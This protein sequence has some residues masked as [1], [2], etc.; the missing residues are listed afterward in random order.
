VKADPGSPQPAAQPLDGHKGAVN[1]VAF[2][3]AGRVF[4]TAGRDNTVLVRD[5]T[6]GRPT[7]TLAQPGE[8]VG[9]AFA[10]DGKSL[11][12]TSAGKDGSLILWDPAEGTERWRSNPR[13]R[14]VYG[15]VAI[16]G[17]GNVVM[18]GFGNNSTWALDTAAGRLLYACR[19]PALRGSAAVASSPDGKLLAVAVGGNV[20]LLVPTTGTMGQHWEGK[21]D[22]SALA[23]VSGGTKLAAADGGR[24]LRVLDVATG[25]ET[26]AFEA[27]D[28]IRALAVSADGQWLAVADAGGTI[29]L[30]DAAAG[31]MERRFAARGPV[32]AV[33]LSPDGKRLATAGEDGAVVWDLERDEKPPAGVQLT[34]AELTALWDDLADRD[35]DKVY[36][37]AR[38]LRADPARSV[39]FLKRHLAAKLI[40]R[41]KLGQLFADLDAAEFKRREAAA[42]ELRAL[43]RSAEAAMRE[44]LAANPSP[45]VKARLERLL[46]P[47]EGQ[48]G[49]LYPGR[50][51]DVRA[52]RVLAQA[53]TPEAKQ[54]LELLA[55][56]SPGWWVARP[57]ANALGRPTP[58]GTKP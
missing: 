15:A 38:L 47:L 57:A 4:A 8:A 9:L 21:A 53:G 26:V 33:A 7:R 20:Q 11:A 12:V 51:R 34:E 58:G 49:S 45:E 39:P 28:A 18:A 31:T 19:G 14:G 35:A 46:A 1:A 6:T 36:A 5:A 10:P 48:D 2:A 44:A 16:S 52:V 13:M 22:V 23:F 56:D 55:R 43:G 17:D 29:S 24:S 27:G 30:W 3:P 32:R 50:Q 54:L 40:D 37:A 25:K 41:Q 42:K